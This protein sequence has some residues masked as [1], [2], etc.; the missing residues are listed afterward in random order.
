MRSAVLSLMPLLAAASPL[1][2]VGTIHKDAAPVL[3]SS[4]AKPVPNSYM[5]VFKKHVKHADAKEH[6]SWVQNIHTKSET[7][8]T[9]LRK[10]SQFPVVNDVFDGLK[11]T[12]NIVGSMMGY[13]G[14]FDDETLE[15]IRRHPDVSIPF[16]LPTAATASLGAVSHRV[17]SRL[18]CY[19]APWLPALEPMASCVA[20]SPR[21]T[22]HTPSHV[23]I[24][25][26]QTFRYHNYKRR[27]TSHG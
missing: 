12:Y 15:Q 9:E 16:H 14:H 1:L 19:G 25:R 22:P 11:H 7:E 18:R 23:T 13:S 6:H 24:S 20:L 26:M 2:E 21:P 10:R 8:R 3:S 17:S 5:V 27:L 4:Y